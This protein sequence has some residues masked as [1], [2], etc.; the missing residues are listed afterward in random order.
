[1]LG[2]VVLCPLA[3]DRVKIIDDSVQRLDIVKVYGEHLA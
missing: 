1:M 3:D 2:I